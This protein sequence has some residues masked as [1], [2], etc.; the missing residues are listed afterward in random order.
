MSSFRD[1]PFHL[2]ASIYLVKMPPKKAKPHGSMAKVI[3]LDVDGVL[4][5]NSDAGTGRSDV[6]RPLLLQR[7]GA[8]VHATSS[9]IVLSSSWRFHPQ[10]CTILTSALVQVSKIPSD[11]VIGM[12]G[13][14]RSGTV[15]R[16]EEIGE[17][18]DT[19][20][21]QGRTPIASWVVIDDL[22]LGGVP[23]L[24][25]HFVRVDPRTGLTAKNVKS[26]IHIL[27]GRSSNNSSTASTMGADSRTG[28]HSKDSVQQD[29]ARLMQQY[30]E[31]R[32][33]VATE[34]IYLQI[35]ELE[36]KK[37]TL[38][39]QVQVQDGSNNG[40]LYYKTGHG[41]AMLCLPPAQQVAIMD[42]GIRSLRRKLQ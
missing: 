33:Q 8:I 26:A 22:P 12:T 40:K 10:L 41:G 9:K 30:Q 20:M 28:K 16:A 18:L 3:F 4:N 42:K 6:L 25:G 36:T 32:L 27:N 13:E 39:K 29:V 5:T 11:A 2:G 37:E 23:Y 1:N 38:L 31:H 15:A 35:Q 17:W 24:A 19:T 34:Q 7:L 21:R 14:A